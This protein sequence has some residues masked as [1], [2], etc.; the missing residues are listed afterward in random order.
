MEKPYPAYKGGQPYIFVCY[1]HDDVEM[2]YP[3]ITWLRDQGFNIWYD[4]GISPGASWRQELADAIDSSDPLRKMTFA[5]LHS[6]YRI[7]QEGVIKHVQV[8]QMS[9]LSSVCV[10]G[11]VHGWR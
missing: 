9:S 4:D 7:T 6:T 5:L 8:T 10:G 3:E 11:C 1:A 2:V